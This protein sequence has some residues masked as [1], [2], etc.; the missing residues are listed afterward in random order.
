MRA[1]RERLRG[2]NGFAWKPGRRR[3]ARGDQVCPFP[4]VSAGGIATERKSKRELRE[5]AGR[6]PMSPGVYIMRGAGE[7]VIYVGKSKVL[8]SRVS[9]YFGENEKNVKTERMVS[10]V[11]DFD[12]ML[13]DTE[14]EALVLE[15]KLI[16]LY[17]P[18]YNILLKDAR[19]YPYIKVTVNEEYPRLLIT[20][21]RANDGAKYFGPYS[22][23][24]AAWNILRTVQKAFLLPTCKRSFPR[25]IGKERPCLYSQIGQ[26]CAPCAGEGEGGVSAGQYRERFPEIL[27]FLRGSYGEVRQS[28][29]EKM[30]YASDNLQFEAAALYRDRLKSLENLWQKQ[31]VV[32]APDAEYDV[33]AL[34]TGDACS[35][36][37]I[38]YVRGGAVIDSDNFIFT[39]EQIVDEPSVISFLCDLYARREYIPKTLLL[40][41]DP[42]PDQ[43]AILETVLSGLSET[44]IAARIPKRGQLR[45][46]CDMVRENAALHAKQYLADAEKDNETLLKLASM[47]SLEVVPEH[48]ESV[49]ISNYGD[50]N[51][52]AGLISVRNGKFD[53][54]GYR[55]YKIRS[56][57]IQDDYASMREALARRIAHANEQPLPD[58]FLL[59]GGKGHVGVVKELFGELGVNVPVFG[60]VKDDFHKTRA[61]T[62]GVSEISIAREQSVFVFIYKIQEEVHRYTI[63]R[64][65]KSKEKT[66]SR[67]GLEDIPGIGAKKAALLMAHFGTLARL[68]AAGADEIAKVRGVSKTDGE[69]VYEHFHPKE[70]PAE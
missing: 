34:Y 52:T 7:K 50:E 28:L 15:N 39:A 64:M 35:C 19:S 53:K 58:L 43:T 70:G 16:K 17:Q 66:V 32:G 67:S 14:I 68:K 6:L 42:G 24:Y 25:D 20:R 60:M 26:C 56:T 47:L 13:T 12:Y 31:K 10:S 51:I 38:Y 18:K 1:D 2:I 45:E 22:G 9:Q 41:F 55:T 61:I 5:K 36:L 69:R 4:Y 48:I 59:D 11:W 21:S 27:A 46:L 65:R 54:K 44:K 33:I 23:N 29:T 62:D 3:P 63:G 57:K 30:R 40:G 49:D 8:K 37:A